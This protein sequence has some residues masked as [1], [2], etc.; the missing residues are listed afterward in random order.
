MR[1]KEAERSS[2]H[3]HIYEFVPE[4]ERCRVEIVRL[5]PF[6]SIVEVDPIGQPHFEG[7]HLFCDYNHE[8]GPFD[9]GIMLRCSISEF[10]NPSISWETHKLLFGPL[11]KGHSDIE[12][13]HLVTF[14]N[15]EEG[16]KN[17]P[18]GQGKSLSERT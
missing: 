10:H 18:N 6:S 16:P 3:Q 5:L 14:L 13:I 15:K 7:I 2:A 17:L 11:V 1:L 12:G 9:D 8:D 4:D